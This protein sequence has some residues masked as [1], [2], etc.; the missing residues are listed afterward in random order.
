MGSPQLGFGKL[1]GR[2]ATKAIVFIVG[3]SL[4]VGRVMVSFDFC[5]ASPVD[6]GSSR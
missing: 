5:Q 1:S 3:Y 6:P 4:Q 2:L